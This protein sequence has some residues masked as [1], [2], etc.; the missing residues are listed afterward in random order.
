MRCPFCGAEDSKVVDSRLSS[1]GDAIRRR[2]MCQE[3][4]ERFTTYETAE[5]SLPRLIKRDAT[6]EAFDENKL[7]A[8]IM[9]AL[10]KRPV[11]IDAIDNAVKTITRRLWA[12]G[13]REVQSRLVGDWVMDALREL[14][15]VAYVR[16]ASVYRSFQDVN[17]FREEIERMENRA[18]SD[19]DS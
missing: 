14:D 16:F 11:S 3:C 18:L 12:T 2:R 10:E 9:R 1:E 15:E 7:R 6:R 17:A 19:K 8:G 4:N 13:E 5:L